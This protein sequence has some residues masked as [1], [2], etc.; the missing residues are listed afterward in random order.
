MAAVALATAAF[1]LLSD[2]LKRQ[3]RTPPNGVTLEGLSI[4]SAENFSSDGKGRA[5]AVIDHP[6]RTEKITG[7]RPIE[8]L[9]FVRRGPKS[10]PTCRRQRVKIF[11]KIRRDRIYEP[12]GLRSDRGRAARPRHHGVGDAG[13]QRARAGACAAGVAACAAQLA[14]VPAPTRRRSPAISSPSTVR[15]QRLYVLFFISIGT[16]RVEYVA[17]TSNP[18]TAWT[19]QH[20]RNLLMELDDRPQRPLFLI[21]YRDKKFSRA[22]DGI[23][24]SERITII[25]TPIQAPNA[26]AYAERW[27]GSVRRDCLDRLLIFNRRQLERVLQ[28][29]VR[30]YNQPPPSARTATAERRRQ[31][32]ASA[33]SNTWSPTSA[34]AR[35]HRRLASRVRSRRV[36]SSLCTPRDLRSAVR[37]CR[38]RRGRRDRGSGIRS[39]SR[40]GS[41]FRIC[42]R[43]AGVP[44]LAADGRCKIPRSGS[45]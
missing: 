40:T 8:A 25:R 10:R 44:Y 16:R 17:C 29:Y 23:F 1:N 4:R 12:Y 20:A 5:L 36:R 28:V 31:R 2:G 14:G 15:L 41:N 43:V 37:A 13:P 11:L 30:H 39:P 7:G 18:N 24:E 27:V 45:A 6:E 33:T 26:N 3:T 42:G 32:G 35:P 38:G 19:R 9:F 22:F 21:H 34:A